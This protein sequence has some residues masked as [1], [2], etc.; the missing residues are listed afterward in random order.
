M[1]LLTSVRY[2][3]KKGYSKNSENSLNKVLV[4]DLCD[5]VWLPEG[6]VRQ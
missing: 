6:A 4:M 1:Q 5:Q 3:K 2:R